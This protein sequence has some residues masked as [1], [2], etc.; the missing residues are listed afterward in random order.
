MS[1][2]RTALLTTAAAAALLAAPACAQQPYGDATPGSGGFLPRLSAAGP[3]I[4]NAGFGFDVQC[5]MGGSLTWLMVALQPARLPLLG[6]DLLLDPAGFLGSITAVLSGTQ[7]GEGQAFVPLP[8]TIPSTPAL[9][10]APFFAQALVLDPGAFAGVFAASQGVRFELGLPPLVFVGCSILNGDPFQLIDPATGTIADSGAPPQVDNTTAAVFARGGQ[11]L[12]VA[13]SIQGTVG[14]ADTST[15]PATWQT[16]FAGGG[17]CYG[18]DLDPARD[19]LWTLTN[20]GTGL[21]ELVALDI[22]EASP[23]F[24]QVAFNTNGVATGNFERWDLSP[25]GRRAAVLTYLPSTLTIVDTDD[26]SPTFLQNLFAAQPVPVDQ[27]AALALANQVRITPDDRYALVL[28]Q[29]PGSTPAEISRFDLLAGVWIDHNPAMAGQQNIGPLSQPPVTMGGAPHGFS[30][31]STGRFAIV[32]GFNSCGWVGRL[33]LDPK[34][35]LGFAWVQ[36]FP[37][38]ELQNA[39][40]A[41]L[42]ADETEVGIGVWPSSGCAPLAGPQ[43]VRLDAAT[44]TLLG[45]VPIPF[46]SNSNTLQNLYTVV[47]R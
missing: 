33:E 47:Y 1:T 43:L 45:T 35:P 13:S 36:W 20:P 44:G 38:A 25:S 28:T 26:S 24:G 40:A 14:M 16:I 42:S 2:T 21:R 4:G 32:S 5:G 29:L 8:L 37:G 23:T 12:F 17:T 15:L 10:G 11:R 46:N 34:D 19:L 41:A 18:L 31:S 27:P 22:D 6:F 7:P 9:L 3:W 30:V 39:W